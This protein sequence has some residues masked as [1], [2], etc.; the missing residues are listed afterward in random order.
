MKISRMPGEPAK[1]EEQQELQLSTKP[2]QHLHNAGVAK[3]H[4]APPRNTVEPH[5]LSRTPPLLTLE[6]PPVKTRNTTLSPMKEPKETN[7]RTEAL[8]SYL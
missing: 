8:P 6:M 4:P 7:L 2:P 1:P 3:E 5:Y